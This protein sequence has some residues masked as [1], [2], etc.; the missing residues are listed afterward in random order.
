MPEVASGVNDFKHASEGLHL[1]SI[2]PPVIKSEHRDDGF[3]EITTKPKT[4]RD[5]EHI[6]S[7]SEP[8]PK[9]RSHDEGD[10]GVIHDASGGKL[11]TQNI[12]DLKIA[13]KHKSKPMGKAVARIKQEEK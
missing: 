13:M 4:K 9:R 7:S 10:E 6:L 8:L 12:G 1:P 2:K 11:H 3:T 5:R